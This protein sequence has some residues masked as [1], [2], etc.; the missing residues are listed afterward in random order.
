MSFIGTGRTLTVEELDQMFDSISVEHDPAI[1][2]TV[3]TSVRLADIAFP[4]REL[5]VELQQFIDGHERFSQAEVIEVK[6][7][8]LRSLIRLGLTH[9]DHMDILRQRHVI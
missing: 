3:V 1:P 6:V 2:S 7:E 5:L 9:Y 8:T 4:S